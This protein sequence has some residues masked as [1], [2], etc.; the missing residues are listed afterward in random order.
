VQAFLKDIPQRELANEL[1]ASVIARQLGIP[2]PLPIVARV[3]PGIM[4][5]SMV[6]LGGTASHVVFA[7][8]AIP[9]SPVLQVM[10][11]A[12]PAFPAVIERLAKW[13]RLGDLYAF[14][15]WVANVD[16]HPGNLLLGGA[17]SVWLIDH[18]RSFTGSDWTR[19]DLVADQAFTNRLA[20]WLTP[21]LTGERRAELAG[22]AE[23]TAAH[24]GA[25]DLRQ[26]ATANMVSDVL[27]PDLDDLLAFLI[28]RIPHIRRLSTSALD[29]LI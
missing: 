19:P 16:R 15:A 10:T 22:H 21:W 11:E 26:L 17:D 20:E 28:D 24:A 1:L 23:N 2:T 4:P 8:A 25:V 13:V 27:G 14:D 7:T 12:G 18:G 9:A 29:M 6:R 5:A 3:D